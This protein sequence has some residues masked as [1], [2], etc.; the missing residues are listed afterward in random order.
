MVLGNPLW[1][2]EFFTCKVPITELTLSG[3]SNVYQCSHFEL[4]LQQ[5][6]LA[7]AFMLKKKTIRMYSVLLDIK[8]LEQPFYVALADSILINIGDIW[9]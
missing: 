1:Q 3:I 5:V 9:H 6:E 4:R 7:L 2:Q 8:T